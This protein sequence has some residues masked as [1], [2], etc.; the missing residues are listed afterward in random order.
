MKILVTGSREWKEANVIA[1]IL[2]QYPHAMIIEGCARGADMLAGDYAVANG[3][4]HVMVPANW[5]H[6]GLAA[7][8]IRNSW[9]L[10]L[11]PNL[12]IAFHHDL[13]NSKGTKNCIKQAGVYNIP[14]RLIK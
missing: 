9:M 5:N 8:P 7:G 14:V 4:P 11:Y 2:S 12:V 13:E 6:Y 3:L 1:N 10:D